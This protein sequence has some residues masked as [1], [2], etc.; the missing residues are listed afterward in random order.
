MGMLA[1]VWRLEAQVRGNSE[2]MLNTY[3]KEVNYLYFEDKK[4]KLNRENLKD[5]LV[6]EDRM[7]LVIT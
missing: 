4:I 3:Y 7:V 1:V 2:Y 6:F 5:D